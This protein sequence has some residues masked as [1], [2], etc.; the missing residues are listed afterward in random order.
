[1]PVNCVTIFFRLRELS[2][3]DKQEIA[4]LQKQV[5][6]KASEVAAITKKLEKHE[7]DSA[8]LQEQIIELQE[9]VHAFNI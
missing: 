9:Q 8:Q 2:N 7:K 6:T 3:Y 1:M 4:R 5:E